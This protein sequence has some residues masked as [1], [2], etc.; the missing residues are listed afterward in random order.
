MAAVLVSWD[1]AVRSTYRELSSATAFESVSGRC[2]VPVGGGKRDG[3]TRAQRVS[4]AEIAR[5]WKVV[6]TGVECWD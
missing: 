1:K 4:D 6:H 2:G 3:G 5:V